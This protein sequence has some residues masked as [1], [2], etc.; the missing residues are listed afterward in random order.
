METVVLVH[1]REEGREWWQVNK[2]AGERVEQADGGVAVPLQD[3]EALVGV[4]IQNSIS[5]QKGEK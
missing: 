1:L 2:V 5:K 3:E 4:G